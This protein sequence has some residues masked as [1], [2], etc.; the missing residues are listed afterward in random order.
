M[1]RRHPSRGST[2]VSASAPLAAAA[3]LCP[4]AERHLPPRP[5]AGD[6]AIEHGV[7]LCR[8]R[9]VALGHHRAVY[10]ADRLWT[11]VEPAICR[12]SGMPQAAVTP[13][14]PDPLEAALRSQSVTR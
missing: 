1:K 7:D 4:L 11:L 3:S 2:S 14:V 10:R 9:Q 12:Y 5:L 13:S 6:G 8:G